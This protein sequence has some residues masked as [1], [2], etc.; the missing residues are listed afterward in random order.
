[1]P[2]NPISPYLNYYSGQHCHR[3]WRLFLELL[4]DE[5]HRSAGE[6]AAGFWQHIGQRMAEAMNIAEC[7]TLEDLESVI[8]ETL[9]QLD[10]GWVNITPEGNNMRICHSACPIPGSNQAH[11]E[12]SLMAMS[13]LLEGLYKEWLHQQGGEADVPIH[14]VKRDVPLRECV[15]HY[16]R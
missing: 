5:L 11:L 16:G 1:M 8:N 10:W 14:C 9:D 15:F 12:T 4:F 7:A 2:D 3:Q 6:G 13:A